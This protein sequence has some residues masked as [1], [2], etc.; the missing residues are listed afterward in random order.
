MSWQY[1][2]MSVPSALTHF[3]AN[4]WVVGIAV[5]TV[6]A[7]SNKDEVQQWSSSDDEIQL[8]PVTGSRVLPGYS[9]AQLG[10]EECV[11]DAEVIV[12]A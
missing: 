7:A 3:V 11:G 4:Q 5:G 12:G 9:V 6:V 2:Y 1:W 8:V 10:G